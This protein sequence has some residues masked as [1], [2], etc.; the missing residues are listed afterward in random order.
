MKRYSEY[1]L[2]LLLVGILFAMHSLMG[3]RVFAFACGLAAIW[4][5]IALVLLSRPPGIPEFVSD[6]LD[7][8][9]QHVLRKD[10]IPVLPLIDRIRLALSVACGACLLLWLTLFFLAG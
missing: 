4:F 9:E 3:P 8:D 2:A 10:V 6:D 5:V 1:L 7:Q